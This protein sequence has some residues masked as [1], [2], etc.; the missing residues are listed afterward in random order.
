MTRIFFAVLSSQKSLISL[1]RISFKECS[2]R[3]QNF[4]LA[5]VILPSVLVIT[6]PSLMDSMI[7]SKMWSLG[8]IVESEGILFL[9]KEFYLI[10]ILN[11]I[12][13]FLFVA[14]DE[15]GACSF[16]KLRVDAIGKVEDR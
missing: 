12:V 11:L 10:P 15:G 7:F 9:Q 14:V 2:V 13:D 8:F 6:N 5:K 4:G 3:L 16:R 1:P